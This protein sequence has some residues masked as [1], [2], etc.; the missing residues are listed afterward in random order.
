MCALLPVPFAR[1][2]VRSAV[3]RIQSGEAGMEHR[4]GGTGPVCLYG[5][6]QYVMLRF[7]KNA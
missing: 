3:Y 5:L 7:Y 1:P 4:C 2:G 6:F